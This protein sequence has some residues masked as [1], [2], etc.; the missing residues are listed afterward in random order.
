MTKRTYLLLAAISIASMAAAQAGVSR[1]Q[2]RLEGTGVASGKAKYKLAQ[3]AGRQLQE[4]IEVEGEDLMPN[5]TYTIK[6]DN[7]SVGTVSTDGFGAFE[8]EKRNIGTRKYTV[9]TGTSVGIYDD[10]GA[11]ATGAFQPTP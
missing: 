9:Q 10:N 5:A 8:W 1:W 6:I 2:T 4:E 3:R 11:V 7:V